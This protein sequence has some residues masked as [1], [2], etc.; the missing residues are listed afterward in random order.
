MMGSPSRSKVAPEEISYEAAPKMAMLD[1]A[2]HSPEDTGWFAR[3][4]L[5]EELQNGSYV[6]PGDKEYWLAQFRH[7]GFTHPVD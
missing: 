4:P 2:S 6:T 7:S 1:A 5:T 3:F